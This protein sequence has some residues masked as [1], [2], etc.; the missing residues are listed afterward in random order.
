MALPFIAGLIAGIVA[1]SAI[2]SERGRAV[3]NETGSRLRNAVDGAGNS[4][5]AA[6]D[7][8]RKLLTSAGRK[9]EEGNTAAADVTEKITKPRKRAVKKPV[10][11]ASTEAVAK[12]VRRRVSGKT[13]AEKTE[14]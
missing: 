10:A 6:T 11:K 14:V 13:V 1:V 7:A 12:P 3:I 4:V 9:T 2:R 8:G 5:R